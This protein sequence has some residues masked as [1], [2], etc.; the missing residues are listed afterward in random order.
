MHL[1]YKNIATIIDSEYSYL[2]AGRFRKLPYVLHYDYTLKPW[3]R[4]LFQKWQAREEVLYR[5]WHRAARQLLN[6]GFYENAEYQ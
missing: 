4:P 3:K 1:E 5:V 2:P 6:N